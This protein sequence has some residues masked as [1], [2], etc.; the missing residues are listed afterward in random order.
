M[1]YIKVDEQVEASVYR[2]PPGPPLAMNATVKKE[3][4]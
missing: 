1:N 4:K 3:E 2:P